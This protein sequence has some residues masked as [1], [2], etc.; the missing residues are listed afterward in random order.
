MPDKDGVEGTIDKVAEETK[1]FFQK[2]EDWLKE[3]KVPLL[4]FIL[5]AIYVVGRKWGD[6][7]VEWLEG[8]MD[9]AGAYSERLAL[10]GKRIIRR[11]R[12][13]AKR[14]SIIYRWAALILLGVA[15]I[16]LLIGSGWP[17]YW[18]GGTVVG[19][20]LIVLAILYPV[21]IGVILGSVANGLSKINKKWTALQLAIRWVNG[22]MLAVLLFLTLWA[23]HLDIGRDFYGLAVLAVC[24]ALAVTIFAVI[25][26]KSGNLLYYLA[27]ITLVASVI[28]YAFFYGFF[29][30]GKTEADLANIIQAGGANIYG[31]P[32]TSQVQLPLHKREGK[33]RIASTVLKD[34]TDVG[35]FMVFDQ[36]G[37]K[38]NGKGELL[39]GI[40]RKTPKGYLGREQDKYYVPSRLVTLYRL[41]GP[42]REVTKPPPP[43]DDSTSAQEERGDV[44]PRPTPATTPS[45]YASGTP[46]HLEPHEVKFFGLRVRANQLIT[47]RTNVADWWLLD[48]NG[49]IH[50]A[51]TRV[52][53]RVDTPGEI[54]VKGG[55][56]PM[57]LWVDL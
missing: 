37:F 49:D 16:F 18:A 52:R 15:I 13:R 23:I 20:F 51:K 28:G 31:Q 30:A 33:N 26:G 38:P 57:T 35:E 17:G 53:W 22:L 1:A 45:T 21:L 36:E 2:L 10:H 8:F 25:V 24:T 19:I 27:I 44:E 29:E 41:G 12:D 47:F 6:E 32:R 48:S 54:T 46:V 4:A 9:I 56:R 50:F 55:N 5:A 11:V 42:K 39:I 40:I 14:Y 43:D 3:G 34:S 7:I